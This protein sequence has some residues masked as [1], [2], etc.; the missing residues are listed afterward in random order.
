MSGGELATPNGTLRL[1]PEPGG[2]ASPSAADEEILTALREGRRGV[3]LQ[4]YDRLL[5]VVDG[6][7]YRILGA[8]EQDHADLVQ[9][10]F[11]QI[12]ISL[13]KRRFAGKCSLA[14]WASVVTCH[15]G[16]S[17][18][19]SRKRERRVIERRADPET[20]FRDVA[21]NGDP[22][23]HASI[24]RELSSV[25]GHLL[26]MDSGRA[27]ALLL[28]AA[29]HSIEQIAELEGVSLAAAQSRLSRGR[30]DLVARMAAERAEANGNT[31]QVRS[32]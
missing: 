14:G 28:H 20:L 4:L 27:T 12:V 11:E 13:G 30:R 5:P 15:V 26:E 9:A 31:M 8:R 23:R 25:R 22:E 7:L 24:N 2:E 18:L 29:G 3:G 10:A 21:A 6:T 16:L 19:R 32:Q 17:A 1:V